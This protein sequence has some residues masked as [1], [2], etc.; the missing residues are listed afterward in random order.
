MGI[1]GFTK[2]YRTIIESDAKYRSVSSFCGKYVFVD[3]LNMLCKQCMGKRKSGKD[4]T[5]KDG[6]SITHIDV[7]LS[8]TLRLLEMGI[9]PV[10][11]FDGESPAEKRLTI[12]KRR[13]VR[14]RAQERCDS[15]SDEVS[16][17]YIKN[18]KKSFGITKS[19][20]RDCKLLLG[21]L[22]ISYI[23]CIGEADKQCAE[24]ASHF[25]DDVAGIISDDTDMLMYD[26]PSICL[27]KDFHS[28]TGRYVEV[29]KSEILSFLTRKAN[30]ILSRRKMPNIL[31]FSHQNFVDFS[32]LMGTDYRHNGKTCR[33]NGINNEELFECFVLNEF[34]IELTIENLK[35]SH[36]T[37]RIS[38]DF[39][40]THYNIKKVYTKESSVSPL[41]ARLMPSK[42]NDFGL[43]KFLCFE[44]GFPESFTKNII[45]SMDN[46][47]NNFVRF[48]EGRGTKIAPKFGIRMYSPPI[49]ER[50]V[51]EPSKH[52]SHK[53]NKCAFFSK[54][55]TERLA[56]IDATMSWRDAGNWS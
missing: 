35:S 3:T 10:Y 51:V 23:E 6:S 37:I 24:M 28:K 39:L 50:R 12:E 34:N 31:N 13:E 55:T 42:I 41:S 49:I 15:I 56:T 46:H 5:N 21:L 14:K 8:F 9:C 11:M 29:K 20:I 1:Q 33:I 30:N 25:K 19:M 17:E 53:R 52:C 38:D 4:V 40:D 32:I 45:D 36:Y 7:L 47:I 27:L 48:F 18:F 26:F 54:F 22:G 44:N 2:F 43:M 16:E